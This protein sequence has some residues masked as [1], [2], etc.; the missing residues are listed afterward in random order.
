MAEILQGDG[1]AAQAVFFHPYLA[2]PAEVHNGTWVRTY[3]ANG[4]VRFFSGYALEFP[5]PGSAE[6]VWH[7]LFAGSLGL[8]LLVLVVGS[9]ASVALPVVLYCCHPKVRSSTGGPPTALLAGACVLTISC[10]LASACVSS[11]TNNDSLSVFAWQM[12]HLGANVELAGKLA[13]ALNHSG[14][15]VI[16]DLERMKTDCPQ[17]IR[18]YLGESVDAIVSDVSGYIV[19]VDGM[20]GTLTQV[21]QKID[22]LKEQA[23]LASNFLGWCLAVPWVLSFLS[24][25]A[26]AIT[27]AIVEKSG[28]RMASR[29]QGCELPCLSTGCVAPAMC[30]I[31]FVGAGFLLASILTSGFCEVATET[32][33]S[34]AQQSF[35]NG[36]KTYSMTEYYLAGNGHNPVQTD[37]LVAESQ[38]SRAIEWVK[39]YADIIAASCPQWKAEG[40][41]IL[42]L[43]TVQYTINQTETLLAPEHI[44]PFYHALVNEMVCG[45][46]VAG[47]TLAAMLQLF[48]GLVCLPL[49]ICAASCVIET[50]V[51]ERSLLHGI[52][53]HQ[54][55]PLPQD[56]LEH[57]PLD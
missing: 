34:Y 2:A 50:L 28:R 13:M 3:V 23:V 35:G 36:S 47:M 32:T 26:I 37:L 12:T 54:F 19:A 5:P 15:A 24:C 1:S 55:E 27:V 39:R 38:V 11:W 33:L 21:P 46:A 42:N 22:S 14:V 43:E 17:G 18:D 51:E 53:G 56:D 30:T 4:W 7:T 8:P 41:S 48:V 20:R 25:C 45:S 9:V 40:D 31:S 10:L 57:K 16:E 52:H 6:D 44:Y 49:L 29:C